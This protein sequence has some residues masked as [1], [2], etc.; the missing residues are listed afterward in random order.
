[1]N[2]SS[3]TSRRRAVALHALPALLLASLLSTARAADPGDD[4][5]LLSRE[6]LAEKSRATT[7]Y[8]RATLGERR[9]GG[10]TSALGTGLAGYAPVQACKGT[11]S[12]LGEM[13]VGLA[14]VDK[15]FA[16][17]VYAAAHPHGDEERIT[18]IARFDIP[19][20]SGPGSGN[21]IPALSCQSWT[22]LALTKNAYRRLAA[23]SAA[24][25]DLRLVTHL[26][27]LCVVPMDSEMAFTCF[28][29]DEAKKRF[30]GVGGWFND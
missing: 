15:E 6:T 22:E 13:D 17:V 14:L 25:S 12:V 26:D 3:E 11:F 1:M 29:W 20:A 16:H 7:G 27:T 9:F 10:L 5:V 4:S 18:P 24:Y 19:P 8:L 23:S 30:V 21:R 28:S 2:D